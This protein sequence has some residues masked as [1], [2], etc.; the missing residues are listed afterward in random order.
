MCYIIMNVVF[1]GF[2]DRP[3]EAINFRIFA[4]SIWIN[5]DV[6]YIL[7]YDTFPSVTFSVKKC[8]GVTVKASA[9]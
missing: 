5:L 6:L 2:A 4:A 7:Q 1:V 9:L 8:H 3:F